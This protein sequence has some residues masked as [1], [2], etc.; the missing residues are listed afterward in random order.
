[1][2]KIPVNGIETH[3][4]QRGQGD[5][6]ILLHGVTSSLA[7]WY[8]GVFPALSETHRVT[9]YDLRGHGLSTLTPTGYTSEAL[10]RDL[11]ALM[12]A[13]EIRNAV[14]IGHSFGGAIALHTAYFYPERVRG[15]VMLDSGLA[16]L[17]YLRIIHEWSGW[18]GRP[19]VF[20]ERGLTLEQFLDLDSKQDITD[21]LRH[22]LNMPRQAGFKKGQSGMTPR[23]QKLLEETK[24]GYEFR[25]VAGFTEECIAQIQ[26]PVLALYGATSPYKKMA[27]RLGE[28]MPHCRQD[29]LPG[30]GHFYAVNRPE[31]MLSAMQDFVAD[32]LAYVAAQPVDRTVDVAST[33]PR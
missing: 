7:M 15:V 25:D 33:S 30:A 21:V 14:L 6:V 18:N 11:G 5:D 31:L 23:Q 28:I 2:P 16:C 20:R 13:L 8:N 12:E 3:Y 29:V 24:L 9:A 4:V 19:E 17:R 26:T 10:A 22:G 32:P 27:E 1:M